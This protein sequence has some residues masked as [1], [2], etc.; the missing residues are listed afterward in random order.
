MALFSK[1]RQF[2]LVFGICFYTA[3]I[4]VI[5]WTFKKDTVVKIATKSEMTVN[6]RSHN[7]LP[8]G[9]RRIVIIGSGPT[10]LGAVQRL[11]EFQQEL[12]NTEVI[13]L[14]QRGQPGGL[15]V[16]ER[17][18]Q[19]FLWDM[20]GHVIFSHYSYFDQTLDRAVPN[21]NKH[22]RAAF[23]YMKGPDDK[24]RFIP[25][26]VQH[27]IHTMHKQDQEKSLSGLE[28]ITNNP[29]VK[30]PRTF[31][32]WLLQKFGKGLCE[33]F[34][35]KYNKKVWTVDTTEMNSVWV[36]E[37]VAVPNATAIKDK[38]HKANSGKLAKDSEWGPNR[39]FRFPRYNGTG[40]IW[41]SVA[42]LL[43][44][45]WFKF[46]EKVIEIDV[47]NKVITI[48]S[49]RN[50]NSLSTLSYST[51]ISTVPL[52]N[53]VGFLESKDSSLERMK[54]I[55]AQLVY[56]HTHIVGIGLTGQ[57]PDNLADK[58]WMYFP[59]SDS[60][61]YRVTVFSKYSKDHV[62]HTGEYW[63]LM[64]ESAEPIRR[65]MLNW[66]QTNVVSATIEALVNY[67]FITT[68]MIVSKYY[69]RLDHGYPVPSLKRD[70]ILKAVQPWLEAKDIFSRGRFGGWK[71]EVG[72]QDHSLMQGV[73]VVDRILKGVPEETYADP[74]RVNS[75]K[76]TGRVVHA[77]LKDYEIVVAHYDESLDWVKSYADHAHVYHKGTNTS[78]PFEMYAWEKLPNVGREG[79][80]YLHHIITHY[81][82]LPN[83]TIFLQA[84]FRFHRGFCHRNPL[85]YISSARAGIPCIHPDELVVRKWGKL[86]HVANFKQDRKAGLM[87][88]TALTFGEFYRV[89]F[90][91]PPPKDGMPHCYCGCFGATREMIRKHPLH[92]YQKAI[93]FMNDHSNPEE[94]HYI[95]RLWYWMFL[96]S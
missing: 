88:V 25:Y 10:A 57:P 65:N 35:R 67:G 58:S 86:K 7:Y 15:A 31:D 39:F 54:G 78:A 82:N 45:S 48:E 21:W 71:Y 30:P 76:N 11:Y 50:Q 90:G 85:R 41:S 20:G 36:G 40:G 70:A 62:P 63:S 92:V 33:V 84:A 13:V 80:T 60:P 19:G 29:P 42:K 77:G 83:V 87:R 49:T 34:M 69:R 23:A 56:T 72:N 89:L 5:T 18:D 37:R 59:D 28:E 73:E 9:R 55:T 27:N 32:E 43:P 26:P 17:D 38:I 94:G 44:R 81:N 8:K 96:N 61:F 64:C 4:I 91:A 22:V 95:E 14:E 74:N 52:D 24:R 53:F 93:A 2:C 3:V 46:H 66:N 68:D 47:D 1:R 6:P 75:Q 16:S 51:L 12:N 79:H